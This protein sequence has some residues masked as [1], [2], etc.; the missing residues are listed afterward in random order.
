MHRLL[1]TLPE[2]R[3]FT[4]MLLVEDA[5][6]DVVAGPFAVC[7]RADAAAARRHDNPS[8]DPL[9]P[10]GDTPLG[11]YRIE[12]VLPSGNGT[13]RP[14][15]RYGPHGVIVLRPTAGDAALADANGRFHL[16]IQ[17]GAPG[18][19]RRL[20]PTNGSLRLGN[21]EQKRLIEILRDRRGIVCEL[22]PMPA[23]AATTPIA[24]DSPCSEGDPP[25]Q[26]ATGAAGIA[27]AIGVPAF[28]ASGLRSPF[29][30][31]TVNFL[32]DGAGGG[33]GSGESYDGDAKESE[34]EKESTVSGLLHRAFVSGASAGQKAIKEAPARLASTAVD[35]GIA[36]LNNELK[37][38]GQQPMSGEQAAALGSAINKQLAPAAG[39][40]GQYLSD[41]LRSALGDLPPD[42][43]KAPFPSNQPAPK[44][45]PEFTAT[46][47]AG[48]LTL[49]SKGQVGNPYTTQDFLDFVH[50]PGLQTAIGPLTTNLNKLSLGATA[51]SAD[52]S[53][54]VSTHLTIVNP[55]GTLH[56]DNVMLNFRLKF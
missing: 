1:V 52:W 15:D 39:K 36:T 8:R 6:G 25:L 22:L 7:G 47:G 40:V 42:Q 33:G 9:L 55:A 19:G 23:P 56:F 5:K 41:Q 26:A 54:E 35:H 13:E 53:A 45:T 4:G 18:P 48:K 24:L 44:V 20:R 29:A 50:K 11:R 3:D 37:K 46:I 28:A 21:R 43:A 16:L 14:A 38:E 34:E 12:G 10:F 49:N 31:P 17:G 32:P 51:K 27:S 2:N 30:P